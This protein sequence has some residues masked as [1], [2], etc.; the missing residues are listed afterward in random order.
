MAD[1][2]NQHL[3][4]LREAL[5]GWVDER[6]ISRQEIESL[7]MFHMY[8]VNLAEMDGWT[9]DGHSL[10]IGLPMSRLV[11][12]GTFDGVPHVVFTSGR[13]AVGCIGAFLRKLDEGW[14]EWSVDRFRQ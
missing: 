3:E 7:A 1:K 10:N 12:R 6:F 2:D 14:L 8:L 9:Y 4:G 5:E 13:T 11:V